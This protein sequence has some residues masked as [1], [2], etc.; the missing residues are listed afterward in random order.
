MRFHGG[1]HQRAQADSGDT[2]DPAAHMGKPPGWGRLK[3]GLET[4]EKT[5]GTCERY[6]VHL[7]ND[8]QCMGQGVQ[9][10]LDPLQGAPDGVGIV[11]YINGQCVWVKLHR[12][13]ALD[14]GGIVP[15]ER[16][17]Y[18]SFS[19]RR[20]GVGMRKQAAVR[21]G[22]ATSKSTGKWFFWVFQTPKAHSRQ[23]GD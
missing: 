21:T 2:H 10:I 6:P 19:H 3:K 23:S 7:A 12:K 5:L 20:L 14:T 4:L 13:R 22:S 17:Q 8:T 11:Q 16:S 15:G 1:A 18:E 9:L